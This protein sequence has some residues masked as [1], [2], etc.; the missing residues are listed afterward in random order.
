MSG[1]LTRSLYYCVVYLRNGNWEEHWTVSAS[2]ANPLFWKQ[3]QKARLTFRGTTRGGGVQD[4][5]SKSLE[6]REVPTPRRNRLQDG[7]VNK[8]QL[9][10][11][12]VHQK[13]R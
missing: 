1:R 13:P 10:Y 9:E 8:G 12:L 7:A 3:I 11:V 6:L 4:L 5:S 2:K